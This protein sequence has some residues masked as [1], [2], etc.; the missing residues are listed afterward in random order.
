LSNDLCY[1]SAGEVAAAIRAKRLSPLEAFAAV[2]KRINAVNPKINGYVTLT[3]DQARDAARQAQEALMRT[4]DIGPLH[5]VPVAVKDDLAIKGVRFTC[6]S[7]LLSEHIAE[8]DDLTVERLRRAGAIILGKTNLPEFGHKGTTDNLL[9]GAT[10]NPWDLTRIA[11]GSSGGSAAVVAAGLAY[12]ALGTD[13]GGSVRIPAS[14]CGVVG[15]KPS[16]GRVPRVPVGNLFNT[17]WTAGPIART[18]A[19]CALGLQVIS[20][21]DLR[22]PFSIPPFAPGELALDGDLSGLRIGWTPSPTG[23]PVEPV[24]ADAGRK[25]LGLLESHG[26]RVEDREEK[27]P[28]PHGALR[29]L[30][31]G[32]V[33]LVFVLAEMHSP[34]RSFL[35]RVTSWFSRRYRFSPSF[36]PLARRGYHT[37]LWRYIAAQKEMTDFVEKAVWALFGECDL[38]ATPTIALPPFPHPGVGALGPAQVAGRSIDRHVEWMFTW[39]F[40]L[41]GQPAVS[42]PCGWTAEG[43]PIGLQL[44]GR[45]CQ[46]G[47]VLRVAAAIEGL[48]PWAGRRPLA[49]AAEPGAAPDPA[50]M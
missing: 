32:D 50:G 39:P 33:L 30:L 17:A 10:N 29:S 46:D 9:F 28:I 41:S 5:G 24:V 35:L 2:E 18:V 4:G 1:W 45:R 26:V 38:L 48:Q 11:G 12:L 42:V 22:D 13:I 7:N 31:A 19:D 37:P 20:G 44:V 15:H 25:T 36:A 43:L 40:N 34:L 23:A 49:V 47:L 16:L 6:G 14:C 8:Y 3:L 21:P 27:L